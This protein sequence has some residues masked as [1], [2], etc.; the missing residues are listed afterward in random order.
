V[1]GQPSPERRLPFITSCVIDAMHASVQSSFR[2]RRNAMRMR[3]EVLNA[4][5]QGD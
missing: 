3:R 4:A 1:S 5:N 2:A